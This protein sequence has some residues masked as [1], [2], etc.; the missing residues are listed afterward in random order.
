MEYQKRIE[1]ILPE[2]G[3]HVQQMVNHALTIESKEERMLAAQTII[4]VMGN[5]FPYLRDVDDFKHKLWDHLALMSDYKLDIDYPYDIEEAKKNLAKPEKIA[6][7]QK[8]IRHKHYGY[9]LQNLVK[10]IQEMEPSEER[11]QLT[12]QLANQMKKLFILWN[13]DNVDDAKIQED[14][15][16]LSEGKLSFE[17]STPLISSKDLVARKKNNK[18]GKK[19]R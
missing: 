9:F 3:R 2:Y 17:G 15:L 8:K 4:N 19:R 11:E 7:P 14:L 1:L 5:M 10:K 12:L 13:K 16:E 6:Y 18:N